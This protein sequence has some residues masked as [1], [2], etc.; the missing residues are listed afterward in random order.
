M[1]TAMHEKPGFWDRPAVWKPLLL[2]VIYLAFYLAVGQLLARVFADEIDTDNVVATAASIL[3][4]VVL[5][6][7]IGA[8][9]LLIFTA[10]VG[11]LRSIFGPQP[12]RGHRWMRIGPILV[13]AAIVAHLTGTDWSAWTGG[14]IVA[15]LALGVCVGLAEELITRGLAVKLLRDAGRSERFVAVISSLLFA[16][17][18]TVNLIS[19]MEASTVLATIVYTFGFG[20]CMYLTMRVTG[21]IWAAIVLHGI[22]DPTTILSTGGLDTA[23]AGASGATVVATIVTIL[24]IVF[25][26]AAIFFIRGRISEKQPAT[27]AA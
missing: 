13:V 5:P 26:I 3:F 8:I 19:G 2:I 25:G 6:I 22:T 17:M 24:L 23:I 12:I 4:G 9:A 11:W 27:A 1:T 15:L 16:L 14:E 7:A 21:T 10:K 20:M 18:H